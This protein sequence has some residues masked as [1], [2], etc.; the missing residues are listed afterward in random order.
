P[1]LLQQACVEVEWGGR[2]G[3]AR[4]GAVDA[5]VA[6]GGADG[7]VEGRGEDEDVLGEGGGGDADVAEA[8][9]ALRPAGHAQSLPAVACD[10]EV[11]AGLDGPGL[12]GAEDV[13]LP[14]GAR[15][16][17]AEEGAVLPGQQ[18]AVGC[19]ADGEVGGVGPGVA[20][21]RRGTTVFEVL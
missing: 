20:P 2:R 17:G 10:A 5:D 7:G 15:G 9:V 16:Q 18:G 13:E 21:Q 3:I 1:G 12:Q 19:E 6:G 14:A 8:E 4:A 11:D